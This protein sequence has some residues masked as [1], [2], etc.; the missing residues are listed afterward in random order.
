[1]FVIRVKINIEINKINKIGS[2]IKRHIT[3]LTPKPNKIDFRKSSTV[4]LK[5]PLKIDWKLK[6]TM[7]DILFLSQVSFITTV[8]IQI[9]E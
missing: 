5:I 9:T 8:T 4:D 1:M 7:L 2:V 3:K 6:F